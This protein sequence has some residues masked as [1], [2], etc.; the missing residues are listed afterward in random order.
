MPSAAEKS[1]MEEG[2]I[3]SSKPNLITVQQFQSSKCP[4]DHHCAASVPGEIE[5]SSEK[6]MKWI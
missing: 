6:T 1:K 3:T 4:P 5:D 2:G